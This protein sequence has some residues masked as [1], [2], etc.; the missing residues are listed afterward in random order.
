[1]HAH[2]SMWWM[3]ACPLGEVLAVSYWCYRYVRMCVCIYAHIICVQ[4]VLLRLL[5]LFKNKISWCW[6]T[7]C[8]QCMR[9]HMRILIYTSDHACTHSC[10]VEHHLCVCMYTHQACVCTH[11]HTYNITPADPEVMWAISYYSLP[12]LPECGHRQVKFQ[13][14]PICITIDGRFH[15]SWIVFLLLNWY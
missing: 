8:I 3:H 10:Y 13:P 4:L 12:W 15:F 5:A 7:V 9:K 1:M 6:F 11:P 14:I 2:T